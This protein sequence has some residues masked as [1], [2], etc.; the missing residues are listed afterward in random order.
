MEMIKPHEYSP[1]H[2]ANAFLL[3]AQNERVQDVDHLKIQ[4]LVYNLNG[5]Y[6]A[7][8]GTS[9]VGEQFRAWPYGPVLETLYHEFKRNGRT[10]ILEWAKDMS[11]S[12]DLVAFRPNDADRTFYDTL[13]AVWDRYKGLSG[14]Q[15]SDLTH[16]TG[17]P[18]SEARLSGR[19]YLDNALIKAEFE[20]IL[21]GEK[22]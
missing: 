12:G 9:V 2:V 22:A 5:F 21:A 18:W 14:L 7:L 8:Y 17:T 16:K 15:L 11:Q 20:K 3:K 1:S 10:R 13:E 4:K 19:T 6:L